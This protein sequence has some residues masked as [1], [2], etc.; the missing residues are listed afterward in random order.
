MAFSL[1]KENLFF[2]SISFN[3]VLILSSCQSHHLK[4]V[5]VMTYNVE[6]LFDTVHDKGKRDWE[7]LPKEFVG[8]EKECNKIRKRGIG[9]IV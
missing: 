6:N 7:Y 8:K 4:K 2:L 1:L 3:P 5:G 9:I